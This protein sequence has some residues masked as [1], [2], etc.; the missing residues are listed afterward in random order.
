MNKISRILKNPQ[1]KK[2]LY[3]IILYN[4]MTLILLLLMIIDISLTNTKVD[5]NN[6]YE[7]V[8]VVSQIDKPYQNQKSIPIIVVT[9]G[10]N[11]YNLLVRGVYRTADL[12]NEI[13]VG[14]KVTAKITEFKTLVPINSLR[15][16]K[17]IVDLRD[18]KKTYYDIEIDNKYRKIDAIG[19]SLFFSM[20][21]IIALVFS[22]LYIRF[23]L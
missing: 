12:L 7:I 1:K 17:I 13:R 11:E 8:G 21:W 5:E 20:L 4:A 3:K 14:A 19:I 6:T 10:N 2:E 15:G 16:E 9:I 22:F 18:D 23:V